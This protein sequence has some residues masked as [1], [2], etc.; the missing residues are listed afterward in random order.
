MARAT[1]GDED[2]PHHKAVQPGRGS[3]K[4]VEQGFF[5][6]GTAPARGAN[7]G[8]TEETQNQYNQI[9]RAACRIS[10]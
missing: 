3:P 6:A 8:I 10:A 2:A 1:P 7:V 4:Y 9:S 5:G